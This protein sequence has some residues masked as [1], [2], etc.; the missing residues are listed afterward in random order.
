MSVYLFHALQHRLPIVFIDNADDQYDDLSVASHLGIVEH[1][2]EYGALYHVDP[3]NDVGYFVVDDPH[4]QFENKALQEDYSGIIVPM[5]T[6]FFRL[7]EAIG[8]IMKV[9]PKD[10]KLAIFVKLDAA[11]LLV[12]VRSVCALPIAG[13]IFVCPRFGEQWFPDS[14][15]LRSQVLANLSICVETGISAAV[16]SDFVPAFWKKHGANVSM[17]FDQDVL[18]AGVDAL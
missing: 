2:N 15:T 4:M 13:I 11:N 8:N 12:D 18:Q 7:K 5:C 9:N 16:I 3:E 6:S 10:R 17:L 14:G 1:F